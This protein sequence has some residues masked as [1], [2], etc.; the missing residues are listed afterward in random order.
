MTAETLKAWIQ[1][2]R[3]P[4]FVAT[5][6][7][8][9]L[10]GV[11][12]WSAGYWNGMRWGVV[13]LASFLVHL[14]TN[15]ANDYF[16]HLA[17]ADSGDSIGGSRVLQEGK[18]TLSEL[19]QAL[20]LFYALAFVCGMWIVWVSGVQ[21]LIPVML[22]SFFSSLFYTAPPFRYG[23]RGLGELFVGINMGPVMVAGTASAVAGHF[24]PRAFW[25]SI[26]VGLMVAMILYYQ[27]LPDIPEDE[28]VGK[29]TIAVRLGRPAAI[30]GM[31]FFFA[32][33]L[34]SLAVL[35]WQGQ[36]H[37]VALVALAGILPAYRIDRMI[38]TTG[39]WKDLHDKGGA[40][41]MFYLSVG[42][43]M[44]LTVACLR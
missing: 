32:A 30:W 35:V 5:I 33:T 28:A 11:V 15:L 37:P 3:A 36:L 16:D 2:S 4:F 1:A 18:I 20:I 19:R 43:T 24:I 14:C 38:A 9:A 31:R 12:T 22:F 27:S 41:R 7:P 13:L 23:Y 10:G 29:R 34:T 42:L 17:G 44:I 6:V 21:W 8:L 39:D 40:V 26:P 25:L